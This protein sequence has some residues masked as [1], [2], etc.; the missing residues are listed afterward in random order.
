MTNM[1]QVDMHCPVGRGQETQRTELTGSDG[2]SFE[3]EI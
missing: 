2:C 3:S 1:L